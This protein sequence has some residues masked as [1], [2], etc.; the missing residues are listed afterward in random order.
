MDSLYLFQ[1]EGVE[2]LKERRTAYLADEQGLGKSVEAIKAADTL[3]IPFISII[4]P[5]I[6]VQ[7]W[8]RKFAEWSTFGRQVLCAYSAAPI[9]P[10]AVVAKTV[11]IQSYES[12]ITHR[13][14]LRANPHRG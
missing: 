4:C 8:A 7:D 9:A 6:A 14:L 12:A 13:K 1:W 3:R 5:K 2:W 10:A 11:L